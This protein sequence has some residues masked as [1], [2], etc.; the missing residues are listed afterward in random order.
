MIHQ[1]RAVGDGDDIVV[2]RAG[3]NRGLR[4]LGEHSAAAAPQL[5]LGGDDV[6]GLHR[7]ARG[8]A[9]GAALGEGGPAIDEDLH[10]TLAM[11]GRQTAV[12]GRALITK[13]VERHSVV[14]RKVPVIREDGVQHAAGR[15]HFKRTMEV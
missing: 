12:V 7:L 10:P 14:N 6:T 9:A 4:L 1:D 15:L 5:M 13:R 3:V 2:E 11:R 8:E